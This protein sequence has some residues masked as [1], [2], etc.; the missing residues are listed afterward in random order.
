MTTGQWVVFG[1]LAA[2]L[3]LFIWNRWR[4]DLVA[5]S[6]L[7]VLVVAG[8][9]PWN[10]AFLGLGHPAVVT[11]AAVLII[12]SG[13][14]NAGVVDAVARLLT[15]VGDRPV[16][17]VLTM[18]SIVAVCSGFMNNV[19][20][21]ALLMP[22][23][24][25]LSRKAGRSPSLLLMPLAFGSLLGGLLTMIGTP[26]NIIIAEYRAQ[27]DGTPFRMFDFFPVGIGLA[28]V[29]VLFIALVGWRLMPGR[30]RKAVSGD[31]FD[32]EAYMMEVRVPA[33]SE[34]VGRTLHDLMVA[35][36]DEADIVVTALIRNGS[37]RQMPS[38]YA[39]LWEDDVLMVEAE[40]EDLEALLSFTGFKLAGE[41]EDEEKERGEGGE[42]ERDK[43]RKR[44][45]DLTLAEAVVAPGSML[46]GMTPSRLQMRERYG[47]NV[48][49]V[50]RRGERLDQPL[51]KTSFVAGDVLLMQ[52]DENE[53]QESLRALGC[54]PL[55][56]RGLRIGRP[57][58]LLLAGG[59]FVVALVLIALEII[60]AAV[61]LVAAAVVMVLS[62][63][64]SPREMYKSVDWPIIILLA[65]M[66][67]IGQALESTGG[68]QLIADGLL[69]IGHSV[70]PAATLAI[71]MIAVMLLSNVVNNAAAAVL[72]AP[73]A[74]ALAQGM[75]VS[76]DP[77]LM[78]VG[79][80]AS[81][82][83]LTPVGHQSNMLVMAPGGYRFGDYWRMGLPLSI[84]VVAC[85][86]P[87][88][89]LVWPL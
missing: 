11:V 85:A 58:K 29:G 60:S 68:T 32:I 83:F 12:S 75:G 9:V 7:L 72:A 80:G 22:V 13:L 79:V 6:A 16:V 46:V 70:P 21:L 49:A 69:D 62:G 2:T 77:L 67:P 82:A 44:K 4:Y 25:S 14:S 53:L 5:L 86:V 64:I 63:L 18:T 50:A 24:V 42:E 78:G 34:F 88:I 73:V 30:D 20:A 65:A 39:V 56:S 17:Q 74:I 48:L 10:D 3:A 31:L 55:A 15:R 57:R 59:I 37:M 19:G 33:D 84:V 76:A 23:A 87:L 26:P 36:Q 28:V 51:S 27:V 89:M 66:L 61:G 43:E 40:S 71:L 45:K 1:V 41:D 35:V 52:G 38:T 8:Y 81:S 47:V 54:L